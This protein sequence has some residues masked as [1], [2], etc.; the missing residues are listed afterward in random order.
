MTGA[1]WGKNA[2]PQFVSTQLLRSVCFMRL[3]SG[4]VIGVCFLSDSCVAVACS[5]P[6]S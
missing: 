6:A 5:T 2:C 3:S 4:G 1:A